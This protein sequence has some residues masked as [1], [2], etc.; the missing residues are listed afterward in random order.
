MVEKLTY[1]E[2]WIVAF[3]NILFQ[4]Q[5][6]TTDE[7]ARKMDEVAARHSGGARVAA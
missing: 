4:K 7:L 6:L 1:Y 2:H 3:A 5:I